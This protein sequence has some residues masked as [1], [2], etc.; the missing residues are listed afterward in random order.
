M[1]SAPGCIL[2]LAALALICPGASPGLA[3]YPPLQKVTGPTVE[4]GPD[5]TTRVTV[6]V[7]NPATG[8]DIPHVWT[9]HEAAPTTVDQIR[10]SQGIVAWRVVVED[11]FTLY[12][13]VWGVYDLGRALPGNPG[14]G[15]MFSESPWMGDV[16]NIL[17]LNDGIL[18]Y[19]TQ[20]QDGPDLYINDVWWTYDPTPPPTP[21]EEFWYGWKSF[22]A[23]FKNWPLPFNHIVNDGVA[24]YI[25]IWPWS[26]EVR[27]LLYDVRYHDW[28]DASVSTFL[29]EGLGITDA[30]VI[31][32]SDGMEQKLG[33]ENQA[34][35]ADSDTMILPFF[36]VAP[37]KP[38]VGQPVWFT[39]LSFAATSWHWDLGDNTSSNSR[40]LYHTYAGSGNYDVMLEATGPTGFDFSLQNIPV[41]GSTSAP[42]MLLLGN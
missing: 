2:L 20:S 13:I 28:Y 22:G 38:R 19:E 37:L 26:F 14:A 41:Q 30:T 9:V 21:E 35:R 12:K 31:W 42:L 4:Q 7:H 39:D 6:S 36:V 3:Y 16:T 24:A 25:N 5:L 15:W 32:T 29:P 17:A 33:Y 10:K 23:S 18:L 1:R 34:W 8:Q 11:F 40:S 27:C